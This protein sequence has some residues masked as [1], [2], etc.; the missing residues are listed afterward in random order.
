MRHSIHV[1]VNTWLNYS[2]FTL[3]YVIQYN[4]ANVV[5]FHFYCIQYMYCLYEV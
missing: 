1:A 2:Y 5:P 4:V 3:I